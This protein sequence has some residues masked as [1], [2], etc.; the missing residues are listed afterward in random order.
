[1]PDN[2][3]TVEGCTAKRSYRLWCIRHYE[4][5]RVDA[6]T[7]SVDGCERASSSRG[8]CRTHYERWRRLGTAELPARKEQICT[9]ADCDRPARARGWCQKHYERW[10]FHGSPNTVLPRSGPT[11]RGPLAPGW[12]GDSIGY[13]GAHARVANQRGQAKQY[14]CSHCGMQAAEWAYDHAD[15]CERI[16]DEG[17]GHLAP[18][19]LKVTHYIPLCV[20]C[21]RRFDREY[22]SKL[23]S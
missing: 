17:H 10:K 16:G 15:P 19:S 14:K 8:W 13:T 21:H 4:I 23:A 6:K 11:A 20:T 5:L 22:N 3:C 7:C 9:Q 12:R 2:T 18:Y 1:M